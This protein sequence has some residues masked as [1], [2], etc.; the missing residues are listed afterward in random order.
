MSIIKP[1][2]ILAEIHYHNGDT[3]IL[4]RKIILSRNQKRYPS[5]IVVFTLQT[6]IVWIYTFN[7][8]ENITKGRILSTL[9]SNES[10]YFKVKEVSLSELTRRSHNHRYFNILSTLTLKDTTM[11][12]RRFAVQSS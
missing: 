8:N 11:I 12:Y 1:F 7:S 10:P 6:D 2:Y 3:D 9:E 5:Q 4:A